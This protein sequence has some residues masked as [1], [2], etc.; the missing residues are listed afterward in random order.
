MK[1]IKSVLAFIIVLLLC[2]GCF[3]AC[4]G[5]PD[6]GTTDTSEPIKIEDG[7]DVAVGFGKVTLANMTGKDAVELLARVSGETD[8]QSNILS[9]DSLRTNVAVEF[10]Y[11]KTEKNVFD[12]RFVFEDGSTQDFTN[13]DFAQA[14]STIYLG[15][16]EAE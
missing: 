8:W 3:A 2:T 4:S 10:T 1:K 16:S 12:V 14:K 5:S 11:T 9:D 15:I 6:A 13:L 7:E